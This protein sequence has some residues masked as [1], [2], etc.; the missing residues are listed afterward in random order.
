MKRHPITP[1]APPRL[2]ENVFSQDEVRR[3]FEV[4]RT[5]GPWR[6]VAG[7]YFKT[8]EELLA[9][10]MPLGGEGREYK[11][12]DFLTPSFR[13][14]LGN[15]GMP[16]EEEIHDIFYSKKLLDLVKSMHGAQYGA[17]FLF[18]FNL[19]G[20]S[21]GLEHGHFDGGSWRGMDPTNTPAWLMNIM[22]K[23]GLFDAWAVKAGQVIT[24]FYDS[25]IDGGFTYW[26]DGPD[27]PPKRL[28]PPFD[29]N[30]VLT[31]NQRMFHRGEGS[32]PRELRKAPEGISLTSVIE[33]DG[34]DSWV[35]STDG[36]PI[37]RYAHRHMRTLF[38]YDAHVFTDMTDVKRYYDHTD[39]LTRDMAFDIMIADLKR[40]GVPFEMPTDPSN[41][42]AFIAVL[43]RTYA[44]RPTVYPPEAM[45][46]LVGAD[47][48]AA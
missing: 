10:S 6:M 7:I 18:Q 29:N 33:A 8:V 25:D 28:V 38:H 14:F 20:P 37:A 17:P 27:L 43:T 2:L 45:P 11:M 44:M 5:R 23:S 22:V 35:V 15:N 1:V 3:L 12:S 46:D 9:I 4:L 42:Q 48:E 21:H 26:P 19:S 24:Y 41:D 40:R 31:H 16:Y 13:G 30:G 36:K 47:R 34:A 32:G 39:D